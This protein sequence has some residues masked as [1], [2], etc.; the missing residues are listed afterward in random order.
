MAD[1]INQGLIPVDQPTTDAD[2]AQQRAR[3]KA[4]LWRIDTAVD[5]GQVT[6][7]PDDGKRPDNNIV[8]PEGR[9]SV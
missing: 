3:N 7:L 5:D 6:A 9:N 2:T 8:I 1:D 4:H